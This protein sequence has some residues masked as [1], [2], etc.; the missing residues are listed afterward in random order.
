MNKNRGFTLIELLVVMAI[1]ALLLGILLPAL[2]KARQKARQV[3]DSTQISQIHKGWNTFST[4]KKGLFPTPGLVARNQYQGAWVPGKGTENLFNNHHAALYSL[5]IQQN[6]ASPAVL[7][8]PSENNVKVVSDSNYQFEE[9][10]PLQGVYWDPNFKAD[11]ATECNTSYATMLL[12]GK[13]KKTEWKG[14]GRADFVVL[15]TRGINTGSGTEY[16]LDYGDGGNIALYEE[17]KMLDYMGGRNEWFGNLCFNDG[18]VTHTNQ[19]RPDGH[20]KWVNSDGG[21][22]EDDVFVHESTGNEAPN[23]GNDA[24]LCVSNRVQSDDPD[25]VNNMNLSWD[26]D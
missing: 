21:T 1:I 4:D 18:H 14:G 19:F 25:D 24:F 23:N 8:S 26:D 16:V 2:S 12:N 7:L 6:Y 15:G 5:L 10:K 9:Y 11:L 20:R 3:K 17:S 22:T 13:R